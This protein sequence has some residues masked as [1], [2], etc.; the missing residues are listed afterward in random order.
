MTTLLEAWEAFSRDHTGL[1]QFGQPNSFTTFNGATGCTHAILQRL[2]RAKTGQHV[3]QDQISTIAGYPRPN[4]NPHRRGLNATEVTR[5]LHHYGIP[6]KVVAGMTF[7]RL[8]T[9][10]STGP[11]ALAVMYGWYP[12]E[13]GCVYMG[14]RADGKPNG[15]AI[16]NGKTQL[17]GFTGRHM[18]LWLGSRTVVVGG[19]KRYRSSANE[20]NHGSASRPE[21]PAFDVMR[22][23]RLRRAYDSYAD[24]NGGLR[25]AW[26]PTA[27][28]RPKGY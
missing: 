18:T 25:Y 14:R 27:H 23:R 20:P 21:K 5:V 15:Y 1:Q 2:I 16:R 12:E 7:D 9:Y 10:R 8:K 28:F 3:T 24:A 17:S 26:I 11:I 4:L 22:T 13:R 19:H 6:M